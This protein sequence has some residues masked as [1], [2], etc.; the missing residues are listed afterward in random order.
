LNYLLDTNACIAAMSPVAS[1]V[2]SRMD[3][4]TAGGSALHIPAVVLFELWYGVTKSARPEAN[5]RRLSLLLEA[6]PNVL[7]FENDDARAAAEIRANLERAGRPIGPYD[8]LIAGQALARDL[9]LVTA[10]HG[11]F[12]RIKGL[13][14]EDWA[15]GT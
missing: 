6:V 3:R 5:S 2:Q 10:N 1:A 9:V 12:G 4:E 15:A 7:S 11:E 8:I 13:R 14:W